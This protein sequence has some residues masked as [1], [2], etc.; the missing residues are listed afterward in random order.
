MGSTSLVTEKNSKQRFVPHRNILD[1]LIH[2]VRFY[3]QSPYQML[4]PIQAEVSRRQKLRVTLQ[5]LQCDMALSC[6]FG[7]Q[8]LFAADYP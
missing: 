4:L 1:A 3:R 2:G 8:L 6:I 7:I 5:L